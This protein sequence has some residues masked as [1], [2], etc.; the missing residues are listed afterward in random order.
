VRQQIIAI[1][2]QERIFRC[3][4]KLTYDTNEP[5]R[6]GVILTGAGALQAE[7]QLIAGVQLKI[8]DGIV[9]IQRQNGP[10]NAS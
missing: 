7:V 3:C 9:P 10:A 5:K 1:D 4:G 8:R 2:D 6:D